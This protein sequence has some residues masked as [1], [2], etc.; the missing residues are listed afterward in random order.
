ML[1]IVAYQRA[2]L[3]R[4]PPLLEAG[5]QGAGMGCGGWEPFLALGLESWLDLAASEV[6]ARSVLLWGFPFPLSVSPECFS[7]GCGHAMASVHILPQFASHRAK[8]GHFCLPQQLS[9]WQQPMIP[10]EK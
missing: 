7:E 6:S 1:V 2:G 5:F 10:L 3:Q 4:T 8:M 9:P